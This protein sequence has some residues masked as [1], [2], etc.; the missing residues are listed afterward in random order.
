MRP[1]RARLLFGPPAAPAHGKEPRAR[2]RQWSAWLMWKQCALY[3][4]GKAARSTASIR[5]S[6]QVQHSQ[7]ALVT[8]TQRQGMLL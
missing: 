6:K 2:P 8:A 7:V 4:Q 1:V 3:L 5:P